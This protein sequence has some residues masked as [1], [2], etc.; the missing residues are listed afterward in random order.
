VRAGDRQ[1]LRADID[2]ARRELGWEP[3]FSIARGLEEIVKAEM[4]LL[5][6]ARSTQ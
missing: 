2:K 1:H 5:A 6:E 3:A 4:A